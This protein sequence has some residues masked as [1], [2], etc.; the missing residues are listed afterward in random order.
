MPD[1]GEQPGAGGDQAGA[2]AAARGQLLAALPGAASDLIARFERAVRADERSLGAPPAVRG[3]APLALPAVA[4]PDESL[5]AALAAE[6]ADGPLAYC[7][8]EELMRL[9]V[10]ELEEEAG[11]GAPPPR[12]LRP[13]E[14][15]PPRNC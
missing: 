8:P 4:T 15:P 3:P 1:A 7:G 11:P 6:A 12:A 9:L 5:G 2:L 14:R 10:A 13:G